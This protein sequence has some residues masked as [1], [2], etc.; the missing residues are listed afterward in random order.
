MVKQ[1]TPELYQSSA[2][3][4]FQP[5][6][7]G[8]VVKS[9]GK[10]ENIAFEG[11]LAAV[12][13]EVRWVAKEVKVDKKEAGKYASAAKNS[14]GISALNKEETSVLK[15]QTDIASKKA[16]ESEKKSEKILKDTTQKEKQVAANLDAVGNLAKEVALKD[17]Q[18]ST[19]LRWAQEAKVAAENAAKQA[20]AA[21]RAM[22]EPQQKYVV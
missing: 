18:T 3:N 1:F 22:G 19:T 2:A 14:E 21:A 12:L 13:A 5:V 10:W 15:G 6:E 7:R 16:K 11:D 4:E 20:I 9:S 8:D 17:K